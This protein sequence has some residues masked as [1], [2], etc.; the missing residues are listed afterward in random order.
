M[1]QSSIAGRAAASP[2][3]QMEQRIFLHSP[4]GTLGTTIAIFLAFFG[5]FLLLAWLSPGPL[6]SPFGFAFLRSDAVWP[7]FVLSL[8]CATALGMQRYARVAEARD[9]PS[10]ALIMTGG[11]RSASRVTDLMPPDARLKG[12]TLIGLA[13]GV[14][15]SFII[16]YAEIREGHPIPLALLLWFAFATIM[17]SLLFARGVEQTRAGGRSFARSLDTELKIDLLRTDRLSVLGRSAARS[18]L[19]WFVVSAVAC[20]FFVGN[21]LNWLTIGLIVACA[22]MG[23]G[24]FVSTMSRIHRQI[25]AEKRAEIERLRAQIECV[26]D[27]MHEDAAAAAKMQGLLAYEAR[28]EAAPEWPYDQPTLIRVCASALILSVP[29]FGQALAQFAVEHFAR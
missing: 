6:S 21:D 5:S 25:R 24:I 9:A 3:P 10:Y 22:G 1:N 12:A 11:A 29:W 4:L 26:R 17:L 16:R 27:A 18:A 13:V 19:V 2:G 7:A 23:A 15:L 28:I 8:L 14:A 20:L